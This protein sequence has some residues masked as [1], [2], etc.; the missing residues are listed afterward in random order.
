[1]VVVPFVPVV[2]LTVRVYALA[3]FAR[4]VPL[5]VLLPPLVA[6][7]LQNVL[8]FVVLFVVVLAKTV[9]H[10]VKKLSVSMLSPPQHSPTGTM[11]NTLL[12]NVEQVK[13]KLTATPTVPQWTQ[14]VALAV[15]TPKKR[16]VLSSTQHSNRRIWLKAV[17][18]VYLQT[19]QLQRRVVLQRLK[20]PPKVNGKARLPP[21]LNDGNR[22]P[23]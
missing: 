20:K 10:L 15:W 23:V 11:R 6:H 12:Q 3:P 9:A 8:L 18:K 14:S 5:A 21:P 13:P 19:R 16:Q 22:R 4:V 7:S 17:Q 1:M 2:Q